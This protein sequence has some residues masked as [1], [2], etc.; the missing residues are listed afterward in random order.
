MC[1]SFVAVIA[2]FVFI[3]SACATSVELPVTLTN[4][5]AYFYVFSVLTNATRD[6]V[7]FHVTITHK[8]YDISP[9]SN[10][11]VDMVVHKKPTNGGFEGSIGSVKPEIPVTLKKEKRVWTADFIVSR[12]LLK[13]RD[14]CFVF[15][16]LA[17]TTVNGKTIS[18]PSV[19]FYELRLQDFAKP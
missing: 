14:V 4:L 7:A 5:D 10:A 18:M 19:T 1:R 15:S 8:Q 6:G 13:N 3:S 17:H 16:V 11:G 9:D 12:E 2:W